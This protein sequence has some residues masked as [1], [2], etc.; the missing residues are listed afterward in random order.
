MNESSTVISCNIIYIIFA[1]V[2]APKSRQYGYNSSWLGQKPGPSFDHPF[3]VAA[4][5]HAS[6][7]S[8][9]FFRDIFPATS[10]SKARWFFYA[11]LA[12]LCGRIW[13]K[14]PQIRTVSPG[15]VRLGTP[16]HSVVQNIFPH[17]LAVNAAGRI[18]HLFGP[19]HLLPPF[20]FSF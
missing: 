16:F 18:P 1:H 15:V 5:R 2:H 20:D 3:V 4:S 10:S 14:V 19:T 12:Q 7:G 9:R 13:S 11:T 8:R 17:F 6:A